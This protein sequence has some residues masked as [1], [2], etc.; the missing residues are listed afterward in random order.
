MWF[1]QHETK[2][3]LRTMF[4]FRI[5]HRSPKPPK[6]H[7][8]YDSGGAV[9]GC[10]GKDVHSPSTVVPGREAGQGNYLI[11]FL[12]RHYTGAT[13]LDPTVKC[14]EAY[15]VSVE[16]FKSLKLPDHIHIQDESSSRK[17]TNNSLVLLP[18]PAAPVAPSAA[19][20]ATLAETP[21]LA[22]VVRIYRVTVGPA[23]EPI[24][25]RTLLL[26]KRRH[27]DHVDLELEA[28]GLKG[29][30]FAHWLGAK[31]TLE[32]VDVC[33]VI[34][35]A[36]VGSDPRYLDADG[37]ICQ[38]LVFSKHWTGLDQRLVKRPA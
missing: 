29:R 9:S 7:L 3:R 12:L 6:F 37:R 2:T 4:G 21:D 35:Q 8:V 10:V 14:L 25:T 24:D 32:L 38:E 36:F 22:E 30:I 15:E 23:D 34:D 16:E 13:A 28:C 31:D 1:E 19:N 33:D 26:A 5:G 11:D 17:V 18:G 20:A 27:L